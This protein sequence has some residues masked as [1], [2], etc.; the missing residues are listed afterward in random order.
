MIPE[1]LWKEKED[2]EDQSREGCNNVGISL[3]VCLTKE[4][5]T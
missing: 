2:T 3:H 4:K 5:H 1:Q